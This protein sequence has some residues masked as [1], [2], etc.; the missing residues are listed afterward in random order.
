MLNPEA[1]NRKITRV[2]LKCNKPSTGN[3]VFGLVHK[4]AVHVPDL[5]RRWIDGRARLMSP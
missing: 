2:V 4:E 1:L 5:R 3:D